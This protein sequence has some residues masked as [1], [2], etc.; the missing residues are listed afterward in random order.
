MYNWLCG[1]FSSASSDRT[2]LVG[3]LQ[4]RID[5][6]ENRLFSVRETS[7]DYYDDLQREYF[8]LEDELNDL[9]ERLYSL[10]LYEDCEARG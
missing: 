10:Q 2:G 8:Q 4:N 6:L 7:D 5:E 3:K 9:Q 1:C